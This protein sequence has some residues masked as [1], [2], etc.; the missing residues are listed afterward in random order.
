MTDSMTRRRALEG[1]GAGAL[2]AVAL[3]GLAPEA[4]AGTQQESVRGSGLI[5]PRIR[6]PGEPFQAIAAFAA[7]GVFI[8]TGSD[9]PGTGL[10]V[11][12]SKGADGFAFGYRNFHFD[13]EAKL[14]HTVR[15]T[16]SGTFKGS[17]LTGRV[18]LRS[19]EPGGKPRAPALRTSFTGTRMT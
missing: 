13:A 5:T 11:W 4:A 2:G 6:P 8:T 14:S 19:F 7:G 12:S 3:A 16:A 9:H 1:F 18:T 15:V 17:R 10:G